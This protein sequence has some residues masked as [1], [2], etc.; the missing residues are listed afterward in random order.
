MSSGDLGLEALW[1]NDSPFF[2]RV[3][4]FPVAVDGGTEGEGEIE[5]EAPA[6]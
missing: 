1:Y 3:S 5:P 2:S 4:S 6:L